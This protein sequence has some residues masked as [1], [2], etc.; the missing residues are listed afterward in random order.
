MSD[1]FRNARDTKIYGGN[2]SHVEG[3]QILHICSTQATSR[4]KEV[5]AESEALELCEFTEVK[6]GDICII[7]EIARHT[8]KARSSDRW[9]PDWRGRAGDFD[10]VIYTAKLNAIDQ[11]VFTVKTYHGPYALE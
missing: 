5:D 11:S 8:A 2:F 10:H 7:K 9:N 6:R 1:Y 4:V 3:N